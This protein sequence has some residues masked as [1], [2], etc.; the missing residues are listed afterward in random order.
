[1]VHKIIIIWLLFFA[2]I[3]FSA[4][5]FQ[6]GGIEHLLFGGRHRQVRYYTGDTL[7]I[8]GLE[9][10]DV[11]EYGATG[12]GSTDDTVPINA[13]LDTLNA[14]GGG[15]LYFPP[16]TYMIDV[17]IGAQVHDNTT[18][19]LATGATLKAIADTARNH[20][21][22]KCDSVSNVKVIGGHLLGDRERHLSVEGEWGMGID[23]R[24]CTNVEI[25]GVHIDSCWGD[26]IY[27]GGTQPCEKVFVNNC[28]INK[29]RRNGI[30]VV[31]GKYVGIANN[32]ISGHDGTDPRAAIILEGNGGDEVEYVTV[33][34]NTLVDNFWFGVGIYRN[35][36]KYATIADNIIRNSKMG[37]RIGHARDVVVSDNLISDCD[38]VGIGID[39]NGGTTD[40]LFGATAIGNIIHNAKRGI[41][42]NSI[43]G[44]PIYDVK[45]SD[46]YI[47]SMSVYGIYAIRCNGIQISDNYIYDVEH[48][49]IDVFDLNRA[50]ISGNYIRQTGSNGLRLNNDAD[51][52]FVFG[53][54]IVDA[55]DTLSGA[56]DALV[57]GGGGYHVVKDNIVMS[58][59]DS[60]P[61][62]ALWI[63]S[64]NNHVIDNVVKGSYTIAMFGG[65]GLDSLNNTIGVDANYTVQF[66]ALPD[67]PTAVLGR[68]W[69]SAIDSILYIYNGA[70][71]DSLTN[72]P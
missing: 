59:G 53:N 32:H 52:C 46:N 15:A 20:A 45:I 5:Q 71:W 10:I 7:T 40:S 48:R 33:V 62:Y 67:T 55:C 56:N 31:N 14:N 58:Y 54:V 37:V 6:K 8:H 2:G 4:D 16:G 23:L 19:L 25:S 47:D 43:S 13:A 70:E 21:I 50:N 63:S 38:S 60:L 72:G 1:M 24:Q 35:D 68:L 69:F 57:I 22:I 51:S 17:K 44:K 27:I 66:T 65:G 28:Y 61:E 64:G 18:I 49:G 36:T 34:G 30:S 3:A 11:R 41:S 42:V 39:T 29:N 26:G 12:D 9:P